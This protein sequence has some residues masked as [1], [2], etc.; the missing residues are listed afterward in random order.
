MKYQGAQISLKLFIK[1]YYRDK[2]KLRARQWFHALKE[3]NT[4][5]CWAQDRFDSQWEQ[6]LKSPRFQEEFR[7]QMDKINASR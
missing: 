5:K 2:I 1:I 3:G 6:I 7:Q 4:R